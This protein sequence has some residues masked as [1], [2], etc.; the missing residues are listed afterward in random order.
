THYHHDANNS[1][2]LGDNQVYV[3]FEDSKKQLWVGTRTKGLN[4]FDPLTGQF[5]RYQHQP[6]NVDSLSHNRVYALGEDQAGNLWVGTRGGGLDL[7]DRDAGRFVH[8]LKPQ[9]NEKGSS[10]VNVWSFYLDNNQQ[11]W[12]GTD[13]G[14]IQY[15]SATG[16]FLH[17]PFAARDPNQR[18]MT[19]VQDKTGILWFGTFGFGLAKQNLLHQQFNYIAHKGANPTGL[20][21]SDINAILTDAQGL[22]WLGM[23]IGLTVYDNTTGLYRT[24]SHDPNDPASLSGN[25]VRDIFEDHEGTLWI[26]THS[27]GI[28]RFDATNGSFTRFMHDPANHNSLVNNEVYII[29]QDNL[30]LLW[31]GTREGLDRF[32]PKTG[33][34]THYRHAPDDPNS[35]SNDQI[36]G[37]VFDSRGDLW[38][39]SNNAGLNHLDQATS[40]ITRYEHDPNDDTSISHNTVSALFIDKNEVLWVATLGG[41]NRF[42]RA[43]Q[44]FTRYRV[45]Q[46][47]SSDSIVAIL[48]DS[49]NNIWIGSFTGIDRLDPVTGLVTHFDIDDGAYI[50]GVNQGAYFQDKQGTMYLAGNGLMSFDPLSVSHE[51]QP[52]TVVLTDFLLLNQSINVGDLAQDKRPILTRVI[53]QTQHLSLGYKDDVLA[54]EFAALH[55]AEP[56]QNQYAYQLAGFNQ[57]WIYTD[58]AHRR[59]TYTNLPAA[60]YTFRVK[61]SNKDGVWNE[62]GK[63][64]TVTVLPPPWKTWWAYTIY[65]LSLLLVITR[66]VQNQRDKVKQKQVELEKERQVSR[67]LK[68]L[69]KLKDEFLANTSHELRTPLNGIIGIAESLLDK[70]KPGS[71]KAS[72]LSTNLALIVH[73][74]KRLTHLVNDILDFSTLKTRQLV[75]QLKPLDIHSISE[76]VVKLS[77]NLLCGKPVELVNQVAADLPLVCGDENRLQQILHN[78]IGNGIKFTKQGQVT[79]SA[80]VIENQLEIAIEDTGVGIPKDKLQQIFDSFEQADASTAREFGGTGLGLTVTKQLV[81]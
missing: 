40:Q 55:F 39:G 28:N 26:A 57:D 69:D 56:Q 14:R 49:Q 8:Y 4:H 66:F 11:F 36:K 16:Q 18:V 78:L 23:N 38:I 62:T 43:S 12:M 76:V 74:G 25:R 77:E 51:K 50:N 41:L 72:V 80:R 13:N 22:L 75:L 21:N 44:T 67:R 59:A 20:P 30:G 3:I 60:T 45:K 17:Q 5:T 48:A 53:N 10:A 31:L 52:P 71:Q 68:Q 73:S 79:L 29:R 65:G 70:I 54:F 9:D 7:F 63:S 42:N 1:N 6:S 35:I 34:F 58:S 46:G 81:E 61:A 2:S 64:I 19:M 24:Y 27:A 15:D 37:L 33:L 32:D 47:L